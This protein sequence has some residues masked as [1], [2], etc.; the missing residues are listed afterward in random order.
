MNN[1]FVLI[2]RLSTSDIHQKTKILISSIFPY[3]SHTF[4]IQNKP[5]FEEH[6]GGHILPSMVIKPLYT[7]ISD[8]M[9]TFY[10]LALVFYW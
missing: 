10:E 8:P 4:S 9:A 6:R 3:I 2:K 1:G 5:Y 7:F